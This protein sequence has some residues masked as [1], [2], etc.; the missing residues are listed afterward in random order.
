L[1]LADGKGPPHADRRQAESVLRAADRVL[2]RIDKERLAA[3]FGRKQ[4]PTS[5][6]E[7]ALHE[8]MTMRRDALIEALLR[9]ARVEAAAGTSGAKAFRDT[10]AELQRWADV[11]GERFLSLRVQHERARG[12]LGTALAHVREKLDGKKPTKRKVHELEIE[13]LEELGWSHWA[14]QRRAWLTL[15]FPKAY[16]PF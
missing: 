16:P 7:K 15:R 6:K 5:A 11:E 1:Q 13:L 9:K 2:R 10:Y 8:R 12:R 14:D 4:K 3:H